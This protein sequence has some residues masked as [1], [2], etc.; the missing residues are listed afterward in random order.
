MRSIAADVDA[1]LA[2]PRADTYAGHRPAWWPNPEIRQKRARYSLPR[3]RFDRGCLPALTEARVAASTKPVTSA[4]S[5][6]PPLSASSSGL[7]L[8]TTNAPRVRG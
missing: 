2:I 1:G 6:A 7:A 3:N 4:W 5:S 8:V